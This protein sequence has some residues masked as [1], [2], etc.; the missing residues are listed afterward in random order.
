MKQLQDSSRSGSTRAFTLVEIL[1]V[2]AII[3][4][5]AGLIVGLAGRAS[6]SK[7]LK[8]A[9]AERDMYVMAIQVYKERLGYYPQD[10]PKDLSS[11][12]LYNELTMT[13]IPDTQKAKLGVE[14]IANTGPKAQAFLTGLRPTQFTELGRGTRDDDPS[15]K[16]WMAAR[17]TYARDSVPWNYNVT[18]PTNNPDG[19]D[20]WVEITIGNKKHIVGN[21][22]N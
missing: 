14:D 2:V 16:E 6:V 1:V 5:L 13:R 11:P 7:I 12:P 17:L 20:L 19:F 3:A 15:K 18:N 10:N 22:K 4:V 9:E 8:R 21:W